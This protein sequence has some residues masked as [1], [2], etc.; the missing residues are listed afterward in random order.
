M[1]A[2]GNV[3]LGWMEKEWGGTWIEISFNFVQAWKHRR[4]D[5]WKDVQGSKMIGPWGHTMKE[6]TVSME[7][8][9]GTAWWNT[10]T[11]KLFCKWDFGV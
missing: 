2:Y 1:S 7:V 10:C 4:W 6:M 9:K 11:N 8:K 3:K 5:E